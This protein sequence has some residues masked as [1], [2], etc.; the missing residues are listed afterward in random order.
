MLVLLVTPPSPSKKPAIVLK[1]PNDVPNLHLARID[2]PPLEVNPSRP[3][4][5]FLKAPGSGTLAKAAG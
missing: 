2:A 3:E 1:H 4:D 5:R